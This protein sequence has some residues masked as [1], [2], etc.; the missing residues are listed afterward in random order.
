MKS[1]YTTFILS[2]LILL[3]IPQWA[4]AQGV[5]EIFWTSPRG[6]FS[7]DIANA[8]LRPK[9]EVEV[10]FRGDL[11]V[12]QT[13]GKLYW[14][15]E[16][17]GKLRR[18]N[19]DGSNLVDLVVDS[20]V[21]VKK[22]K[23]DEDEGKMYW[24][25]GQKIQRANLDGSEIEDVFTDSTG[26]PGGFVIDKRDSKIY[27]VNLNG[28]Q[29]RSANL[30][31]TDMKD[32]HNPELS[33]PTELVLDE[34]N[35]KLYWAEFRQITR[36]NLDGTEVEAF[37]DE[38][39]I[40][41]DDVVIDT[42]ENAIIFTERNRVL[43]VK[44]DLSEGEELATGYSFLTSVA[45]DSGRNE[46]YT[47]DFFDREIS[48]VKLDN[49][50]R[51]I[52][53]STRVSQPEFIS[54][55]S[56]E[57]KIYW[58]DRDARKIQRIDYDGIFL[59][60]LI[61]ANVF[62]MFGFSIDQNQRIMYWNQLGS[63]SVQS[64]AFE[65]TSIDI[66][67]EIGGFTT[68]FLADVATGKMYWASG[69][70]RNVQRSNFDGT[71]REI[72]AENIFNPQTLAASPDGS[73]VFWTLGNTIYRANVDGTGFGALLSDL[74]T[75]KGMAIDGE[76]EKLYW[77]ETGAN[78]IKR[79]NFDGTDVEVVMNVFQPEHLALSNAASTTDNEVASELPHAT[80]LLP[81]Y[82]NPFNPSTTISYTLHQS[83]AI[84]LVVFDMLGRKVA[85]LVDSV[86]PSGTH[87]I[88]FDAANLP[89]GTYLYRLKSDHVNL[90]RT[91]I[92]LK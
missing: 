78:A 1:I 74:Q 28:G 24:S 67:F 22:I 45:Y 34:A 52:I 80:L 51:L 58:S 59:E 30:D 83:S 56:N 73:I 25:V 70:E 82:P 13:D 69:T 79:A 18:A 54:L 91:M 64:A 8:N 6:V 40:A 17:L 77:A 62:N 26:S 48:R 4:S 76:T 61:T 75:P 10:G 90:T 7:A 46:L 87:E 41:V 86:Q 29:I 89:S 42:A 66:P 38:G 92:L 72:I 53:L 3:S 14:V 85:T 50:S 44:L 33:V 19:L 32:L 11:A 15:D 60:D 43:R 21:G 31:G 9:I 84:K 88:Q 16:G 27:W 47:F 37:I 81:N 35:N 36:A 20:L 23:L 2:F 71:E 63:G 39:I 65:P 12:H 49:Q 5:T 55:D 57:R 68:A